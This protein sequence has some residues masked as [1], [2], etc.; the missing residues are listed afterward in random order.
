MLLFY[1][2]FSFLCRL[3]GQFL[4]FARVQGEQQL[5]RQGAITGKHP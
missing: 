3:E 4:F 5:P 1:D 2:L